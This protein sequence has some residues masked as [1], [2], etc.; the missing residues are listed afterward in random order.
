V[1]TGFDSWEGDSMEWVELQSQIL[2]ATFILLISGPVTACILMGNT[3]PSGLV[4][5]K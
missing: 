2:H 1:I 3:T 4:A 5:T